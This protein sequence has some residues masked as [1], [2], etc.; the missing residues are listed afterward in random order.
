MTEH[1]LAPPPTHPPVPPRVQRPTALLP[2]VAATVLFAAYAAIA[3]RR[4]QL[5]L[6]SGFDLGIFEQ[7]VRS[8]AHGR[9]PTSSLK[10]PGFPLLGDHFSPIV[11]TL[12]PVYR[13]FPSAVTLL[14]AQAALL[15]VAAIPLVRH[16]RDRLGAPAAL[17]VA[18]GYGLSWGIAEAVTFDFHEVA[19]AVP[20]IAFAAVAL[21]ERRPVHAVAWALPLVLVKE[22]LGLTVA[23]VGV[24][25]AW[26]GARGIGLLAAAGGVAATLVE[27]RI[28]IP[29]FNPA[30][31][32]AYTSQISGSVPDQFATLLASPDAK[33]GTLVALL[34]PTAFLAVRSPVFLL[35]VPTLLWRFLA[36]NPNYWGTRY[37]YSAVLMP[38]AFAAFVDVLSGRGHRRWELTVSLM[39]TALLIPSHPLRY[40]PDLVK[41]QPQ[42]AAARRLLDRVPAGVTVAASN[43]LAPQLTA[44]DDVSLFGPAS[45]DRVHPDYIVLDTGPGGSYPYSPDRQRQLREQTLADG[46]QV[47]GVSG[48]V[49]ILAR[50]PPGAPPRPDR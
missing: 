19:F 6:T 10:G 2:G 48:P 1:L 50:T 13:L 4:H 36:D 27:T 9:L 26:R 25:A 44:R 14:V 22:D 28:I 40:A 32:D 37:H 20:L 23:A 42:T 8:Y 33:I 21:A 43:P 16:A 24:L 30:G 41:P 35:A 31:H 39:A 46:Y 18:V 15:A 3:V 12:A 49:T 5:L 38:I 45:L 47:V 29:A 7:E 11:A 17:V 34:T